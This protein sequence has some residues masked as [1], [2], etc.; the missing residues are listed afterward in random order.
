MS[1]PIIKLDDLK[2]YLN[3]NLKIRGSRSY[4]GGNYGHDS[5]SFTI[6]LVLDDEVISSE[7]IDLS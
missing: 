4:S 5:N 1:N 3:E 7:Y 2:K 6:E